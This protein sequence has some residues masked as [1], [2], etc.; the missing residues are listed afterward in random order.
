[1]TTGYSSAGTGDRL[2]LIRF[3]GKHQAVSGD[4]ANRSVGP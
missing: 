4:T 1:M 2:E 3:S